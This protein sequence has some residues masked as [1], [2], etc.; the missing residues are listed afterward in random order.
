M[1]SGYGELGLPTS[2][3]KDYGVCP[4]TTAAVRDVRSL[5]RRS[6]TKGSG[7]L[8]WCHGRDVLCVVVCDADECPD[9]HALPERFDLDSGSGMTLELRIDRDFSVSEARYTFQAYLSFPKQ[10]TFRNTEHSNNHIAQLLEGA[11]HFKL[12]RLDQARD[13]WL[14]LIAKLEGTGD[15]YRLSALYSN[16]GLCLTQLGDHVAAERYLLRALDIAQDMKHEAIRIRVLWNLA[17]L[18][19]AKG[20]LEAALPDLSSVQQEWQKL[21]DMIG[22]A[23]VSLD[24]ID[25]LL[26]LRR[27]AEV[28]GTATELVSLLAKEGHSTGAMTA[29]AFLRESAARETVTPVIVQRVRSAI[30]APLSVDR[31]AT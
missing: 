9:L 5:D 30:Q 17:L 18:R 2:A 4:V 26:A 13:T 22:A 31:P 3:W 1:P 6:I 29:L 15:H 28:R 12:G 27:F 11:I 20:E 8:L 14:E 23:L 16:I 24:R 25:V 21:G 7:I 19:V 10:V